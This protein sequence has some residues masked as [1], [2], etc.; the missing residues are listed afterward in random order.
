MEMMELHIPV[1]RRGDCV[2]DDCPDR[3]TCFTSD[4]II[5]Y[6]D[7]QIENSSLTLISVEAEFILYNSLFLRRCIPPFGSII[8]Q[9]VFYNGR[10]IYV[11]EFR[12]IDDFSLRS[13][14]VFIKAKTTYF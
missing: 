8:P 5:V 11:S 12:I 14:R 7:N 1:E 13:R 9:H 2:C 4:E 6:A 10:Y 3:F